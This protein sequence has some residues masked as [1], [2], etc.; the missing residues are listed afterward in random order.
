MSGEKLRY[1]R[2]GRRGRKKRE[3]YEEGHTQ[4]KEEEKDTPGQIF[5][6]SMDG[7][8]LILSRDRCTLAL[9]VKRGG[10]R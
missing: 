3:R 2:P 6:A 8:I 9:A 4:D 1:A 10:V 5:Y 7:R